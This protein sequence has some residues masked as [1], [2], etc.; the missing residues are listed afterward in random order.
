MEV[1]VFSSQRIYLGKGKVFRREKE[2]L[3]TDLYQL[4]R[5]PSE[6]VMF[7]KTI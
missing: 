3:K 2:D 4:E 6:N 5:M 1:I 7:G